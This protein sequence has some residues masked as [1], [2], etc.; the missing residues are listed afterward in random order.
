MHNKVRAGNLERRVFVLD[1][2]HEI[3]K[4][5]DQQGQGKQ[6]QL[7]LDF[8]CR[9]KRKRTFKK[10]SEEISKSRRV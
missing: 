5:S 6:K 10:M 8:L 9:D 3:V 4:M 7:S 2:Q 1:Y